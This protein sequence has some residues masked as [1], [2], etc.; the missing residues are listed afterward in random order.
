[1][2]FV[3][4]LDD[5]LLPEAEYVRSG[6]RAVA[7]FCADCLTGELCARMV[8]RLV[9]ADGGGDARARCAERMAAF[10]LAEFDS[11][12]RGNSF[13]RL[14][15]A[16]PELRAVSAIQVV[17]ALS[18][19]GGG[20]NNGCAGALESGLTTACLVEVYRNHP[21]QV[22]LPEEWRSFFADLRA[23]GARLGVISDGPLAAQTAKAG[24]LQLAR[25]CDPVILTDVWGREFWKPSE[26]AFIEIERQWQA[27]PQT[28]WYIGDNPVK[29]FIAPNRRGWNTVRLRLPG[30]LHGHTQAQ[31]AEAAAGHEFRSSSELHAFLLSRL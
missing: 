10:L 2:G 25:Y 11:G 20:G 6:M 27:A 26:R 17:K 14:L 21:P 8:A 1:M 30:Q 29:D 22:V 9:P 13:D 16:F 24:A 23:R 12:V 31:T 7:G 15:E 3:F 19:A 18:V 5:T 4:D 28:L